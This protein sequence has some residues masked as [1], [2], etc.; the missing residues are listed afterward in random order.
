ME[1]NFWFVS[2]PTRK[3]WTAN[4]K[5]AKSANADD[6]FLVS[7]SDEEENKLSEDKPKSVKRPSL[8]GK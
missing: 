4:R 1:K 6:V 5:N 2:G 8:G 3:E 7:S